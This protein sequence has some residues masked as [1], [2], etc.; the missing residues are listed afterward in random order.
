MVSRGCTWHAALCRQLPFLM[1]MLLVLSG[2]NLKGGTNTPSPTAKIQSS[3]TS[4]PVQSSSIA[5]LLKVV[6]SQ[7]LTCSSPN[8]QAFFSAKSLVLATDRLIYDQAEV[9]QITTFV[10]SQGSDL[11]GNDSNVPSTPPATL[12][13]ITGSA[14]SFVMWGDSQDS[15]LCDVTLTV[16][17]ISQEILQIPQV[18]LRYVDSAEPNTQLY[19]LIN[20]CSIGKRLLQEGNRCPSIGAG[21]GDGYVVLYTIGSGAANTIYSAKP[22]IF[23][24]T[25]DQLPAIPTLRP[26][27]AA[28]ITM[29]ITVTN[30][31]SGLFVSAVP[32]IDVTSSNETQTLTLTQLKMDFAFAAPQNVSCYALKATTFVEQNPQIQPGSWCV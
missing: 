18:H 28:K 19:R 23:G 8:P 6:T 11:V 9:N 10:D 27:D 15:T 31:I 14:P 4:S 26:G 16:T 21:G 24:G 3:V 12:K 17:N 25:V 5:N 22:E 13:Y 29:Q 30:Y 2:C 20:V 32:E 1:G 7:E